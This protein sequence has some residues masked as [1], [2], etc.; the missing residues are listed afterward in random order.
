MIS[1]IHDSS[2][3]VLLQFEG[4]DAYPVMSRLW[5]EDDVYG[6]GASFRESSRWWPE[7]ALA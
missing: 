1:S 7:K 4:H 5:I 2:G 6:G 3:N